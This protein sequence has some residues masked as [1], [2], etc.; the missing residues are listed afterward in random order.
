MERRP[1]LAVLLFFV[2]GILVGV[3]LD[4][5]VFVY[6]L[7]TCLF[8]LALI[9]NPFDKGKNEKKNVLAL[10]LAIF[11]LGGMCITAEKEKIRNVPEPPGG[12]TTIE[13]TVSS[14]PRPTDDGVNFNLKPE[15]CCWDIKV[16]APYS[17]PKPDQLD[18]G[19]K[20]RLS[21]SFRLPPRYRE[22]DYRR[23]LARRGIYC[24]AE[25][26]KIEPLE[27][28]GG[29]FLILLGWRL[30]KA[31]SRRL[32]SFLE[33]KNQLLKGILLGEDSL[34]R[35]SVE[36]NF[37]KT[38]LT[39]LLAASGLH[40]GIIIGAWWFLLSLFRL[41]TRKVYLLSLPV[42]FLYLLIVG[43]KTP[44]LRASVIF[45]LGG[46]KL[47]AEDSGLILSSWKDNYQTLSAAALIILFVNPYSLF[48]VGF[49]LSFSA[50]F[51]IAFLAEEIE[52]NLKILSN[53]Y[54]GGLYAVS[55]G[56]FLGIAPV[57]AVQFNLLYPWTPLISP[58][59]IL[60]TTAA[61]YGGLLLALT[62][63]L[64]LIGGRVA[65]MESLTLKLLE[66]FVKEI[67][68]TVKTQIKLPDFPYIWILVYV[69]VLIW[70]KERLNKEKDFYL[71]GF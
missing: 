27:E 35:P 65:M 18:Y 70:F 56:A 50:T 64:P 2:F 39:H 26:K 67:P 66:K 60:I 7:F 51:A 17:L 15:N 55:L 62:G 10:S 8:L 12:E 69:F 14:Y 32:D 48:S 3:K 29:N 40:L 59:A 42:C 30:R 13:G 53:R 38:G 33:E 36:K 34:V 58:P 44:I 71:K 9:Y 43:F 57:I 24:I 25:A 68:R 31:L 52:N 6:P 41:R 37:K 23:Y 20:I 54:V 61:L 45:F 11:C 46:L 1:L 22:F 19:D 49:Q 4:T 16:T 28:G 47:V 21:G 63:G 5:P